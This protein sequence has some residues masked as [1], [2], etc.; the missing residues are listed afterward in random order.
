M[1]SPAVLFGA[2]KLVPADISV[3]QNLQTEATIQLSLPAPE[4]GLDVRIESSDPGRML[5]A[6]T[7]K[8]AGSVSITLRVPSG[9]V[10]TPEFFVQGLAN[11][12]VGE[13]TL[14]VAGNPLVTGLVKLTPSA[15]VLS[16]PAKLGNPIFTTTGSGPSI[17]NVYAVQLDESGEVTRT[18]QVRGGLSM[19][20]ALTT[21]NMNVAVLKPSRVNIGGG[22]F[23]ATIQFQPLSAGTTTVV[24]EGPP[25]FLPNSKFATLAATVAIPGLGITDHITIGKDL[26]THGS[27]LLGEAAPAGGVAATVTSSDPTRLLLAS[28]ANEIGSRTI[29]LIIP[30]GEVSKS[31]FLQALGDSGSVSYQAVAPGYRDRTGIISLAP[32]G[33][34]LTGPEGPPDEAEVLRPEAPVGPHGL[35]SSLAKATPETIRIYPV[36]LDPKTHRGADI[37]VQPIRAGISASI[38]LNNSN[39]AIGTASPSITIPGGLDQAEAEFRPLSAGSTVLSLSTPEGFVKPSNATTLKVVVIP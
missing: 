4:P 26:Q 13:Y 15:V 22:E 35:L 31:Y 24:I 14:S 3:A 34:V 1:A 7:D 39:P 29:T 10:S 5:F 12:G 30:V 19:A 37:T 11:S 17:I 28:S 27:L 6:I 21:S 36:Y 2:A 33:F 20:I 23:K 38:A 18:Q 8:A 25:G 9:R 32:S 16:G